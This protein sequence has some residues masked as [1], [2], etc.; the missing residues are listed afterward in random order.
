[1]QVSLRFILFKYLGC[2]ECNKISGSL[3]KFILN[4]LRN[5]YSVFCIG[6]INLCSYFHTKLW[7]LIHWI[8][9]LTGYQ[10]KH[11]KK[12]LLLMN[13]QKEKS[14]KQMPFTILAKI[15][16]RLSS[17]FNYV[18]ERSPQWKLA[19]KAIYAFNTIH[20]KMPKK[21]L[22]ASRN[23]I[24]WFIWNHKRSWIIRVSLNKK[25]QASKHHN[26]QLQ[27]ILQS[28]SN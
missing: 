6:Y 3:S 15:S 18:S 27:N 21:F 13:S 20:V 2:K 19:S 7:E 10:S 22:T 26:T 14:R 24:L 4:V 25:N 9:Q 28:Y 16:P 12:L 17:Q 8:G 23:A 11:T 5:L 1:M